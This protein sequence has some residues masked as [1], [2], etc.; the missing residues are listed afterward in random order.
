[1]KQTQII[2]DA[3]CQTKAPVKAIHGQLGF[4]D[5]II[6]VLIV[7]IVK[8]PLNGNRVEKGV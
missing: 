6:F 8:A 4:E 2:P 1:V 5:M 7:T 3:I